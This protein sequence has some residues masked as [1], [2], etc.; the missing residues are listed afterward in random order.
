M[1]TFWSQR[2]LG[3]LT[4]PSR[5]IRACEELTIFSITIF[6]KASREKTYTRT[7]TSSFFSLKRHLQMGTITVSSFPCAQVITL[8]LMRRIRSTLSIYSSFA[9]YFTT[10]HNRIRVTNITHTIEDTTVEV[11]QVVIDIDVVD[12]WL[13]TRDGYHFDEYHVYMQNGSSFYQ[14]IPCNFNRV[15]HRDHA[16]YGGNN[17]DKDLPLNR[18]DV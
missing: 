9:T 12:N 10:Q 14:D 15:D 16:N 2:T 8:L 13:V 18:D 11:Y 3:S 1:I 17:Y 6:T 7:T 4:M 5:T